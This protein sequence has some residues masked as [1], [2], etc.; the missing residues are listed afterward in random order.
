MTGRQLGQALKRL[1]LAQAAAARQLG[2]N[3]RTLRRWIAG[4]LPVPRGVDLVVLCWREHGSFIRQ[5][6]TSAP[7]RRPRGTK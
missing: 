6:R 2:V 1:E 7:A 3:D 4:D 5:R